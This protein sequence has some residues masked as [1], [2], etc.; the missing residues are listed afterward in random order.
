MT[1][2]SS[3]TEGPESTATSGP[4]LAFSEPQ[5]EN[6][7]SL[8]EIMSA[9]RRTRRI[10]TLCLRGDLEGDYYAA[11]D[12]LGDLVDADG[13]PLDE[14]AL[15]GGAEITEL[16]DRIQALRAEMGKFSRKIVFE[17]M[18]SDEWDVF[19][20]ERRNDRGEIKD[21][22]DYNA[23]LIST[24][25]VAPKISLAEVEQLRRTLM[26]AQFAMLANMA[27]GACTTGGLDVPKSPGFSH[28]RK[29]QES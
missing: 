23:R 15:D 7:L 12:R 26:P 11:I 19:E 14:Q 10:A 28:A 29:Q 1:S 20:K 17:G 3:P 16:R 27:F 13:V 5:M 6:L 25:A 4:S 21:V 9:A 22:S 8:D 2:T 18:T 24:C